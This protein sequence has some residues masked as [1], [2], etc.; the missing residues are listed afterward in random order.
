MPKSLFTQTCLSD[1]IE[2]FSAFIET[3]ILGFS[4]NL[5]PYLVLFSTFLV[6][7]H[8]DTPELNLVCHDI[9]LTH[10]WAWFVRIVFESHKM[11][12]LLWFLSVAFVLVSVLDWHHSFLFSETVEIFL[13]NSCGCVVLWLFV[14]FLWRVTLFSNK[15]E[16]FWESHGQISVYFLLVFFQFFVSDLNRLFF[17]RTSPICLNLSPLHICLPSWPVSHWKGALDKGPLCIFQFLFMFSSDFKAHTHIYTYSCIFGF[18]VRCR[19]V[20]L[21]YLFIGLHDFA[22]VVIHF[23]IFNAL[24]SFL[25][26]I[27]LYYTIF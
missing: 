7:G 18:V 13:I 2:C 15:M 16:N 8:F 9:V 1:F 27:L 21:L 19:E 10:S 4:F 3:I 24:F 22:I 14:L 26:L 20:W 12:L 6:F 23:I 11:K 25:M 5:W 17:P